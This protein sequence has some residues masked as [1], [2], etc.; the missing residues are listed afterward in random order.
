M[1]AGCASIPDLG[2]QPQLRTAE[3]V[4]ATASLPSG[5]G[6]W[7][8]DGWWQAYGDPQ[9]DALIE[10]ARHQFELDRRLADGTTHR[11]SL[12]SAE[13]QTGK[14]SARLDGPDLPDGVAHVWSWF[15]ELNAGRQLGGFG[16]SRISYVDITAWCALTRREIL[17][18]EVTAILLIDQEWLVSRQDETKRSKPKTDA[19]PRRTKKGAQHGD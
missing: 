5:Q 4:S 15:L 19:P 12:E 6:E 7:P 13:R 3:T 18:S 17:P 16:P 1:L 14:R 10:Y 11:Q 8:T 9:L 2:P